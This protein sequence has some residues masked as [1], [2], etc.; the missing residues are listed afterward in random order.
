M[1]DEAKDL[2]RKFLKDQIRWITCEKKTTSGSK[3]IDNLS[4]Q[5]RPRYD[6]SEVPVIAGL[7]S[8]PK[9]HS[10]P[11]G[12]LFV[13]FHQGTFQLPKL[14]KTCATNLDAQKLERMLDEKYPPLTVEQANAIYDYLTDPDNEQLNRS[15][16]PDPLCPY[17]EEIGI[18]KPDP[19]H[20]ARLVMDDSKLRDEADKTLQQ[21]ERSE[22]DKP[23]IQKRG[24]GRPPKS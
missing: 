19:G 12:G 13:N 17:W 20:K 7:T 23:Q 6:K 4:F 15:F 18:L 8:A 16:M 9:I 14:L 2:A 21:K 24:P 1:P 11:Y 10:E 3:A 22:G 5:I